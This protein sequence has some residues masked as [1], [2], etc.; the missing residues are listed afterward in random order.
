M[1]LSVN[2]NKIALLRNSRGSDY[3]NLKKFAEQALEQGAEGI[4]LH[5]RPDHRHAT[6]NDVIELSEIVKGLGAEFNIEGNP[7]EKQ[8][9]DYLGF[10]ELIKLCKPTQATLVP[11]TLSQITSDHGWLSGEHDNEL[12]KT[13]NLL[14]TYANRVS[15][16]IDPT[17]ESVDYAF[18]LNAD[19]IELYTE[20]YAK[21]YNNTSVSTS[22]LIENYKNILLH[23]KTLGLRINAGH[24]LNLENLPAIRSLNLIDEVSIGHAIIV[25]A[26]NYGF[27]DTIKRYIHITKG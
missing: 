19:A 14:K 11:D 25:D 5:P 26:L 22:A 16:F 27:R 6:S 17:I 1:L 9:G 2:L 12:K 13:I 8:T 18:S 10:N 23:A 24:D 3:P 21:S 4:T 20:D 7:F 15:L